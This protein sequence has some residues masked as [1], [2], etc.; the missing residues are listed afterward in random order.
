MITEVSARF[1]PDAIAVARALAG[2]PGL[3][4]LGSSDPARERGRFSFVAVDPDASSDALD[5]LEGRAALDVAGPRTATPW[6]IGVLPY[7]ARRKALERPAWSR[8]EH[9][10]RPL[11][12][13]IAWR[14]YP[15]VV[16]IDHA[17]GCVTIVGTSA[18]AAR[19]LARALETS[20]TSTREAGAGENRQFEL[21][22][23]DADAPELHEA[24]VRE[25]LELIFAGDVYEVNL[26]RELRLR[27]RS[28][29]TGAPSPTC[30]VELFGALG[31]ASPTPFGAC[32][33][34]GHAWTLSTSPELFLDAQPS[35]DRRSFDALVTE[36]I[37]GTRPRG[38]D[39]D[40]DRELAAELASDP[41]ERAELAMI[42]D[43][44]R[45]DLS[46]VA[47]AGSVQVA[48]EPRVEAHGAVLHRVATVIA[49]AR[50][51][52][53]RTEV[54]EALWPSGSVTGAPKVRAMEIIAS[55]E[56]ARRGLYT[57]ALGYLALDGSIRMS[58]AI[59]VAILSPEGE[60]SYL[61]GGGIVADSDPS[62]ELEETRWKS[63]QLS[64]ASSR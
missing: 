5:P 61:T 52:V 26:A 37:K 4:I 53:T 58:M 1:A 6:W 24:R 36:P 3:A 20:A 18:S 40:R 15:A 14:R 46:R 33:D 43:V 62:R 25:A 7:E 12:D 19:D 23:E 56:P 49:R 13:A 54:L 22:V 28:A 51:G 11:V 29:A 45:N 64:L 17:V 48:S 55:L 41:K 16:R 31:R 42:I 57:G 21:E 10:P 44:E 9:R 38:R 59:R 35:H 2:R 34:L 32:F 47:L 8:A 63:A 60:G 50:P 39:A 30:F 27:L